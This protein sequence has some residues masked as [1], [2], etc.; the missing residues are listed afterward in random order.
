M[1]LISKKITIG[2]D[3]GAHSIKW[4]EVQ[5]KGSEY[6]LLSFY[7]KPLPHNAIVNGKIR[8]FAAVAKS[9]KEIV[10]KSKKPK[11][12]CISIQ[13]SQVVTKKIQ[14]P[15]FTRE[16]STPCIEWEIEQYIPFDKEG[17]YLDY[18]KLGDS[19]VVFVAAEK[20][21]VDTYTQ[22]L[23]D[24]ETPVD[25]VETNCMALEK[26]WKTNYPEDFDKTAAIISLGASY[27]ELSIFQNHH[28]HWNYPIF[29]NGSTLT[30]MI[31]KKLKLTFEEA[32]N[33]KQGAQDKAPKEIDDV[34]FEYLDEMGEE[35]LKALK[36][37]ISFEPSV[38]L[39]KIYITG[40]VSKMGDL[41]SR[42]SEKCGFQ[43]IPLEIF[44][45]IKK[46]KKLNIKSLNSVEKQAAIAVGL[47]LRT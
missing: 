46:H 43:L 10:K 7:E 47:A 24:L 41:V 38:S 42:L 4:A 25:T 29:S 32:E 13:G 1:A 23:T 34:I 37:F 30:H 36:T 44:K 9:L 18:Y 6:R 19:H 22:F 5:Q 33:L 3:I 40:G 15:S 14:V 17:V 26:I 11:K 35:V 21:L 16:E 12:I 45:N 2:C 20:N 39:D 31:Q 8:D 28:L 27:S